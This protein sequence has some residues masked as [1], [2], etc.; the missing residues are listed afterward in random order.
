MKK[1]L[2]EQEEDTWIKFLAPLHSLNNIEITNYFNYEPRSNSAFSRDNLPRTKGGVFAINLDNKN[3]KGT[4]GASLF[5]DK[6]TV[7][8]FDSFGILIYSSRGIK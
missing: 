1:E 3:S 7:V 4:Y 5:T 8:Y 2:E 6:N